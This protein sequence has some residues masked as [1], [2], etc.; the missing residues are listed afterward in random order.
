MIAF[1]H[2]SLNAHVLVTTS[3]EAMLRSKHSMPIEGGSSTFVQAN[4]DH[5]YV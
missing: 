4:L 5:T 1:P 3:L 2:L